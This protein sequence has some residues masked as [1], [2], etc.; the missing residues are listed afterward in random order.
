MNIRTAKINPEDYI[1][2]VLPTED[3]LDAALNIAKEAFKQTKSN[4]EGCRKCGQINKEKDI[5][6]GK[7]KL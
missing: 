6:R 4:D 3:R 7:V 5:R 2:S 1:L